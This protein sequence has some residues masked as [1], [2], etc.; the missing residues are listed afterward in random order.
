MANVDEATRLLNLFC[1]DI[2]F[3][4]DR[5]KKESY[6]NLFFNIPDE[7]RPESYRKRNRVEL[8]NFF[9]FMNARVRKTV[10]MVTNLIAVSI[11]GG[12]KDN[13]DGADLIVTF[14]DKSKADIELK[15]GQET[16]RNIGNS[17]MDKIFRIE[18]GETFV[19][20]GDKIRKSQNECANNVHNDELIIESNLHKELLSIYDELNDLFI[21]K[22][23]SLDYNSILSELKKSGSSSFNNNNN[24]Y[25]KIAV[26]YKSKAFSCFDVISLNGFEKNNWRIREIQLG[27]KNRINIFINNDFLN[28]KF[29]LN[30][31][32]N[33]IKD[34][35][36]YKAKLGL[37]TSNWNVWIKKEK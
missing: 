23:I 16:N 8:S 36:V 15:F 20:I 2:F 9:D 35:K 21:N 34:G 33:F 17:T 11:M 19:K 1:T 5:L 6:Y 4:Y 10:E 22:K 3:N 13:K 29:V 7:N 24:K 37:G 27:N 25:I 12:S 31:K 30:W 14:N 26:L 32:N 28:A 18:G